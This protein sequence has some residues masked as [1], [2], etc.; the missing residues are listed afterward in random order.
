MTVKQYIQA[1]LGERLQGTLRVREWYVYRR[2]YPFEATED[3]VVRRYPAKDLAQIG[4][5][6]LV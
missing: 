1:V 4:G 5:H 6:E 2:K 3:G